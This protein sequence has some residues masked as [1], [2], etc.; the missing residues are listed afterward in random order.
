MWLAGAKIGL[1]AGVWA[2][3]GRL[4]VQQLRTAALARRLGLENGRLAWSAQIG[5]LVGWTTAV[6][7]VVRVQLRSR[8][9]GPRLH[10]GLGG[11]ARLHLAG[12]PFRATVRFDLVGEPWRE[13]RVVD[14]PNGGALLIRSPA[15]TATVGLDLG[16]AL[17]G[18]RR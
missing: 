2:A 7:P 17:R 9:D 12:G 16:V 13:V 18:L 14:Q 4:E 15:L 8:T 10:A 3:E 1:R 11:A 5:G 6:G